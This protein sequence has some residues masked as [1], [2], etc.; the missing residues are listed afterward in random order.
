MTYKRHTTSFDQF[1]KESKDFNLVNEKKDEDIAHEILQDLLGEFDPWELDAMLPE[2]ADET[3]ASYG[4]K[5][6]KAKKI[7][8][9]LYDYA[10]SGAYES[11]LS[12]KKADGTI[13]DDE[14]EREEDLMANVEVAIDDLIAMIKKEA[15]DIGG[16][17]RSPGIEHRVSKLIKAKLQKARL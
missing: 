9:L 2:D 3:V 6:A 10:H 11:K 12:E 15:N 17:F 7:A 16:S 8:E 5:G 4:Y 13:S 14:E 1:I